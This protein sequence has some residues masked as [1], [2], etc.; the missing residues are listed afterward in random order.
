M[1]VYK[2]QGEY[3]AV[4]VY[5]GPDGQGGSVTEVEQRPRQFVLGVPARDLTQE[6]WAGLTEAEQ[7]AATASGLYKPVGPERKT[8]E[9]D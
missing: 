6:E 4:V 9:G 8:E 3:D 5:A 7:Q 1:T 2:Y